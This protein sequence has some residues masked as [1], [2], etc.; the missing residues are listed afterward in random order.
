MAKTRTAKKIGLTADEQQE[1]DTLEANVSAQE[2]E[3]ADAPVAPTADTLGEG[4]VIRDEKE[5]P[6]RIDGEMYHHVREATDG[7]WIYAPLKKA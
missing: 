7:R 6:L 4:E 3:A 1:H 2:A 5:Q